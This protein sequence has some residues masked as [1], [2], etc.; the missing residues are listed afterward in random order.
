[1]VSRPRVS[2]STVS[3]EG[4]EDQVYGTGVRGVAEVSVV[5][6]LFLPSTGSYRA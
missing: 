4:R 5:G 3:D 6:G 2:L 1:M